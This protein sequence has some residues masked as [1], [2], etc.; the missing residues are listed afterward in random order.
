MKKKKDYGSFNVAS[1]LQCFWKSEGDGKRREEGRKWFFY[2]FADMSGQDWLA[3][4]S[5]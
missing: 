5:S 2:Y 1:G 3:Y 4:A